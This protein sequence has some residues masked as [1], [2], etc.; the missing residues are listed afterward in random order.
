MELYIKGELV[1]FKELYSRYSTRIYGFLIRRL[2]GRHRTQAMDL[3]QLTWLK[4][5]ESRS[6]FDRT[7]KFSA[8]IFTIALNSLRDLVGRKQLEVES[9][10]LENQSS[11]L[12]SEEMM[13]QR[14]QWASLQDS[15]DKISS[16]QREIFLLCDWEGFSSKEVAEM[17]KISEGNARQILMRAR[18]NLKTLAEASS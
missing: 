13:I 3:F 2:T 18:K 10:Q 17:V 8:W 4:L 1:A 12:D 15:L 7:K 16:Q 5:H 11:A 9:D 14:E 6:R